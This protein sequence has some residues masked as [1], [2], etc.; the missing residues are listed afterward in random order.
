MAADI[1]LVSCE[2]LLVNNAPLT[3]ESRSQALTNRAFTGDKLD[4]RNIA[5]AG[6]S[7]LQGMAVGIVFATGQSTE[8]GKIAALSRDVPRPQSPLQRETNRMVRILTVVAVVL[9][10]MFFGYGVATGRPL[11]INIV[12]MLGIIVA[13]V[14][15]GLLPTFT[16]ALSM[17][18]L[19]MAKKQCSSKHWIPSNRSA[20]CT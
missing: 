20:P 14:P 7:V 15:E 8:F 5:F 1:R 6:C 3:G 2:K 16:L 17:A 12:F 9:G 18:S 11:W 4:S 10:L 19:R 13:N